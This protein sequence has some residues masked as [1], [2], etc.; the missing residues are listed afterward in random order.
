MENNIEQDF[1]IFFVK[2][3]KY[4][5]AEAIEEKRKFLKNYKHYRKILFNVIFHVSEG[6]I[7]KI[8]KKKYFR[9]KT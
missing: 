7:L 4:V 8:Y 9:Q 6:I 2:L 1:S 5:N 3:R